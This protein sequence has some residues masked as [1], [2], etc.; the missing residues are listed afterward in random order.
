MSV[1]T[2]R[3]LKNQTVIADKCV[4]ADRFLSRLKGLLGSPGLGPGEGLL[5]RPCNDV[6]MWFMTFPI[7]IVFLRHEAADRWRVCSVRE[8]VRPWRPLPLR[9]GR[10]RET[11]ELPAGTVAR[12]GLRPGDE[13]CIS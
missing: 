7:D 9:D 12:T 8:N 1:V 10:A 6:H 11:L 3:S 13:V 4:V 5:L 2:V